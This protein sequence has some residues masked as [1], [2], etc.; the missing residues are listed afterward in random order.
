MDSSLAVLGFCLMLFGRMNGVLGFC[1]DPRRLKLPVIRVLG[2]LQRQ[3]FLF[4]FTEPEVRRS[5]V[6]V[7]GRWSTH[8]PGS[9]GKLSL[10]RTFCVWGH[11]SQGNSA[12]FRMGGLFGCTSMTL[13]QLTMSIFVKR[14]TLWTSIRSSVT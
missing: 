14:R 4:D 11:D 7:S 5:T 9:L 1:V 2:M 12:S 13:T 3:G 10:S 8:F 6:T